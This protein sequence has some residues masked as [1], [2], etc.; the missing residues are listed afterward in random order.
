VAQQTTSSLRTT[1]GADLAGAIAL[2]GE[3]T[4][5]LDLRLG[6]QHEY[7]DP[8]RPLTAAFAGAPGNAFTVYGATPQRDSAVIGFSA[9]TTIAAATQL[10]LRYDGEIGS[11]TD[12]HALN[13]GLRIS[14]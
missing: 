13:V 4:L 1:F 6:W 9:S 3:R 2:G 12:N 10:Y 5:A 8:S 14:W 7:A 11:G